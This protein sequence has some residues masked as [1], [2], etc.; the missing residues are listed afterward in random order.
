MIR[1]EFPHSDSMREAG[2]DSRAI[3]A[4]PGNAR[5]H[6]PHRIPQRAGP[7]GRDPPINA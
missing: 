5:E 4:Q 2:S 3:N 1:A 6:R 7:R